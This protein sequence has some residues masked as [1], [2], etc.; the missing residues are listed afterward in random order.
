[1][2]ILRFDRILPYLYVLFNS[3][4]TKRKMPINV[5]HA[6]CSAVM[7]ETLH[8]YVAESSLMLSHERMRLYKELHWQCRKEPLCIC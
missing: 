1:M 4:T 5:E 8:S 3:T 6:F 2:P 7:T